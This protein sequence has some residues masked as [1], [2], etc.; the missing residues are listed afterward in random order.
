MSGPLN[1]FYGKGIF[2]AAFESQ[3]I[4]APPEE[5]LELQVYSMFFSAPLIG[6]FT[7]LFIWWSQRN[8]RRYYGLKTRSFFG[9]NF[10]ARW[11]SLRSQ[12]DEAVNG[13]R[14][15][16]PIKLKL[17]KRNLLVQPIKSLLVLVFVAYSL[18]GIIMSAFLF[19]RYGVSKEA[20]V[21]SNDIS[22][23]FTFGLFQPIDLTGLES[24]PLDF[25]HLRNWFSVGVQNPVLALAVV[26]GIL[27]ILLLVVG[28]WFVGFWLLFAL[29]HAVAYVLGIPT[30][31]FLNRFTADRVRDTAFG[32][33]TIGEDVIQVSAFPQECEADCGLL[34]AEV[35]TMLSDFCN[36]HAV[37][38]L[39]RLRHILGV[40]KETQDRSDIVA[41]IAKEL[42][43]H[44]LIHTAYFEVEEIARLIAYALHEAKL[45]PFT[46]ELPN[47]AWGK[48]R[49]LYA[50]MKF[51]AVPVIEGRT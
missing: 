33:D 20:L 12:E 42:T 46:H 14:A 2:R 10:L 3:G 29:V 49:D 7:L 5:L 39:G 47:P 8:M 48:T 9:T 27:L 16:R 1:Y 28:L 44:E 21:V 17:F 22:R 51:A 11:R 50:Q 24:E 23:F 35:E 38:V 34:P 31:S 15:T 4:P 41:V 6:L 36:K 45:A 19:Y 32:N 40:S 26:V 13:L 18:F 37:I 30:S 43:S 25:S